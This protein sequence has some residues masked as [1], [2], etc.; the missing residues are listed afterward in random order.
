[1]PVYNAE[2]FLTQAIDSVLAQTFTDFEF[3]ILDDG[4]SDKSV[5][6]VQSYTDP[7]IRFYQNEHNMGISAT[8]NKGIALA[9]TEL[10]A[11]MDADD[12]C[13][14]ER[15]QKQYDYLQTHPDCAL[16]S[17]WV[18]VITEE[19]ELVRL[20][21]FKS[22]YYY[23]NLTF[24][25]WIYHPTITFRKQAVEAIGGYTVPYSEDFELF[26]QLSRNH[27]IH[28]LP[29]L[30]LDYRI[31]SQSLH[32]V[33]KKTE[34]DI[35]QHQQVLRN[36]RYYAGNDLSVPETYIECLR[37][38]FTPL[39][40]EGSLQDIVNCLQVLDEVN[41]RILN[42]PNPN[43]QPQAIKEA[44]FYKRNFII[45]WYLNHLPADKAFMLAIRT[46]SLNLL[47]KKI[48]NRLKRMVT[49]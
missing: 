32:Q 37:H 6:I 25:C 24:E 10:I 33:Q 13:Y 1:M 20:D 19:E 22:P 23:Y 2:R 16:V 15:L 45:S 9:G 21:D 8:L 29:E 43:C 49:L 26:W 4:S 36:M 41:L 7:R 39:L 42:T 18:R 12:I 30:L 34:Y 5:S 11:R 35:A 48:K 14:P 28:N 44:A 3:L 17:A 31:S 38:N 40:K 46:N 27:K 47:T